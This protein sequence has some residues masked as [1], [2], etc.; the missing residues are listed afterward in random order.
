ML[1]L[2]EHGRRLHEECGRAAAQAGLDVLIVVGG[3]DAREL[4]ASAVSNGMASGTVLHVASNKEAV[5]ASL[6][7]IRPGDLVLV[8]GSRGIGLDLVVERLRAE[9]A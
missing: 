3:D 8:K 2:G 6:Q 7:R 5:E 9:F 1:E 4:A